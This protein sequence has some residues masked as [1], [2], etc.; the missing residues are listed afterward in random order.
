M[1]PGTG[2]G[3]RSPKEGRFLRVGRQVF[4]RQLL[5]F[6]RPVR[7]IGFAPRPITRVDA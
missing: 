3:S 5:E 6:L 4:G 1:I 7:A 2:S